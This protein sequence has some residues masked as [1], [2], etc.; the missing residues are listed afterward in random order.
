MMDISP[1]IKR[2]YVPYSNAAE[3]CVIQSVEDNYFPG[4]RI[5][6][7]SFPLTISA[8]QSALFNCI[9][10]GER[11]KAAY[12]ERPENHLIDYWKKEFKLLIYPFKKLE[13][14]PVTPPLLTLSEDEI[15]PTLKSFLNKAHIPYSNYPVSA[16]LETEEGFIPGVNIE[17]SEWSYGLCAERVALSRSLSYGINTFKSIHIHTKHGSYT[18][19]CGACRQVLFEHL[20][21][22]KV[23]LYHADQ[24][25]SSLYVD[26]LLPYGFHASELTN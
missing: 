1:F 11:P 10:A 24:T 13:E 14:F 26:D 6:N 21:A 23:H 16:L 15:R 7:A 25:F 2:S 19:P 8:I 5:E 22:K 18:S 12:V 9:T 17:L 4:V 3:A 20:S